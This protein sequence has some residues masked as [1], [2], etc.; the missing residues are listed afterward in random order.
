MEGA[1]QSGHGAR[2]VES[3]ATEDFAVAVIEVQDARPVAVLGDVD[4]TEI[5]V[6]DV[7]ETRL[8]LVGPDEQDDGD[9]AGGS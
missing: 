9:R 3:G 4:I 8:V 5:W 1:T 6:A 7:L 2:S